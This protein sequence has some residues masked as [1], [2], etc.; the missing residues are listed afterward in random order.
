MTSLS[1][2][3]TLARF[4]RNP[5][6]NFLTGFL[7]S[8]TLAAVIFILFFLAGEARLAR[9]QETHAYFFHPLGDMFS[10][11]TIF[12]LFCD[13]SDG[14]GRPSDTGR[15]KRRR[16]DEEEGEKEGR[17][18]TSRRISSSERDWLHDH[19]LNEKCVSSMLKIRSQLKEE[20]LAVERERRREGERARQ[21]QRT[22]TVPGCL[23]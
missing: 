3:I 11:L 10:Y 20:W 16:E 21:R 6:V 8:F 5:L 7:F 15:S 2:I 14:H 18:T 22:R 19:F 1:P 17:S 9:V 4:S 12:D 13:L 23:H